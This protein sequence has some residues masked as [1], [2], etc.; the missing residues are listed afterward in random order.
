MTIPAF[1]LQPVDARR[2]PEGQAPWV[3][4]LLSCYLDLLR[5]LTNEE[6]A[7][8]AQTW[9]QMARHNAPIVAR[10]FTQAGQSAS[11]AQRLMSRLNVSKLLWFDDDLHAILQCPPFSVLHTPH[12]VKAFGWERTYTCSFIDMPLALLVYGPNVWLDC[13][14]RC[15]R[16]GEK[17]AFRVRMDDDFNLQVDAPLNLWR[18]WLPLPASPV[19]D[20]HQT[21]HSLRPRIN[22]FFSSADLQ[23]HQQYQASNAGVVYTLEQSLYLSECLMHAYR[24]AAG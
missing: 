22:A 24:Y 11:A 5:S 23:T 16:S 18:V 9:K 10:S 20:A 15:P 19:E 12:E 14:S 17:L 8:Y 4:S 3:D 1:P 13:S 21:F 6:R 2:L 7:L